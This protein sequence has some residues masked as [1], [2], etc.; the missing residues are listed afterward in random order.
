[1]LASSASSADRA[2]A[3][4]PA[5][6]SIERVPA[7]ALERRDAQ[8]VDRGLG[9]NQPGKKRTVRGQTEERLGAPGQQSPASPIRSA[10]GRSGVER[11]WP[12]LVGVERRRSQGLTFRRPGAPICL[13]VA[14][15]VDDE[16][17]GPCLGRGPVGG[18]AEVRHLKALADLEFEDPAIAQFNFQFAL[19][20]KEHMPA[21]APGI[22]KWPG[23]YSTIRTLRSPCS[24]VRQSACPVS[25][26]WAIRGTAAQ[27]FTAKG[28]AGI[29]IDG[30]VQR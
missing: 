22:P 27:S 1:M 18:I 29:I 15:S 28:S 3:H 11:A 7:E 8:R 9:E 12:R 30:T 19:Q 5:R 2:L 4:A 13:I 25:P 16:Y 23:L 17:L 21:V 6:R 24:N 10:P 20:N 26:G 14:P